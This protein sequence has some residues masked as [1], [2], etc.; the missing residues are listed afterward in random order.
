MLG[1]L[2]QTASAAVVSVPTGGNLAEAVAQAQAGDIL[3][4]ASGVYKTKLYIDKPLTIEGPADRSA[5]IQGD[6][7]GR[8]IA[9]HA[10]N[11]VLRN[12]TVTQS[13]LSLPAMDAGVYLEETAA[14]ALV[15]N[16]NILENS[17]GV[18]LHG[19]KNAMVRGNKIVGDTKL[20]VAERGNGVTVWN[21][22]G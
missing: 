1:G 13:G 4:L 2:F 9:V 22:P 14:N 18:Y 20:R 16:N 7:S 8:T 21:A 3:K 6:R 19:P 5:K 15:E 12:L 17:V 11:V 10:P